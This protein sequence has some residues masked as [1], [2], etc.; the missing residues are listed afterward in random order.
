MNDEKLREILKRGDPAAGDPGLAPE[1]VQGMRRAVLAAVPEP[2]RRGWLVP[3]LAG[4]AALILAAVIAL[5][6][7]QPEPPKEAVRPPLPLAGEGRGE[8]SV[9][10]EKTPPHRPSAGLPA[11]QEREPAP[12]PKKKEKKP[13]VQRAPEPEPVVLAQAEPSGEQRQIQFSTP[14]GTRVIWVLNPATE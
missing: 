10:A 6:L 13:V 1:E 8:G 11:P 7:W 12:T 2:R 9:V 5:S 4:A 3:A 14:G